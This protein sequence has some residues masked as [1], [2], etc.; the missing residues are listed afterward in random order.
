MWYT[1][2]TFEP[3]KVGKCE[4]T[5]K[6]FLCFA[7]LITLFPLYGWLVGDWRALDGVSAAAGQPEP[8]WNTVMTGEYQERL[9]D[10][11]Q[12]NIPGRQLLIRIR[13][14]FVYTA[15]GTSP[16]GNVLLGRNGYLYEKGY[17]DTYCQQREMMTDAQIG[18][19]VGKLLRLRKLLQDNGK[20]L[21]VFI[22]PSKALYTQEQFPWYYRIHLKDR[23]ESQDEYRRFVACAENS[24]LNYYDAIDFIDRNEGALEAPVFYPTGIHWDHWWAGAASI[25]FVKFIGQTSGWNLT[26]LQISGQVTTEEVQ[27]NADLYRSMNLLE[28]LR[29]ENYAPEW[30]VRTE[31]TDTPTV[32]C[33]GGS[34]LAESLKPLLQQGVFSPKSVYFENTYF[35]TENFTQTFTVNDYDD[36]ALSKYLGRSDI[37]ILEVNHASFP[38]MSFGLM[39]YLLEHP[40]LVE[41]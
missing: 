20:E 1:E 14:Q 12:E 26:E 32:F 2:N 37:V 22:T 41:G 27:P 13:N 31:G 17:L 28:W 19:L 30:T 16:N 35:A 7:L 36:I 8:T 34:F 38:N 18:E 40:Q 4:S 25:D 23:D 39:D 21:Y 11:W 5:G 9:N 29:M 10:W 33:R 3:K 6:D 24:G 15:T